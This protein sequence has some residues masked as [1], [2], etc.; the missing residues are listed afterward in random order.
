MTERAVED[1]LSAAREEW[2]VEEE[3]SALLIR[4][5]CETES[6]ERVREALRK[7]L[8]EKQVGL[9]HHQI[10]LAIVLH[11]SHCSSL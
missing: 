11:C 2:R 1:A 3:E 4:V 6:G 7:Q 10:L 9:G 5:K 8:D